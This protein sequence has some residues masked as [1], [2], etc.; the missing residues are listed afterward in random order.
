[1]IFVPILVV[2][3]LFGGSRAE[4]VQTM[5]TA[6]KHV[7]TDPGRAKQAQ[8]VVAKIAQEHAD[9]ESTIIDLRQQAL[10]LDEN[11]SAS[12]ADY[13]AIYHKLDAAWTAHQQR[14]LDLRFQLRDILTEQEWNKVFEKVDK[15]RAKQAKAAA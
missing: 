13:E 2:A 7:V 4:V 5:D 6:I 8:E 9:L 10:A 3:L 15:V 12:A 11:P 1:M 14:I